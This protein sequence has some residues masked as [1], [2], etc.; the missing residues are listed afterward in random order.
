MRA[1][2]DIRAAMRWAYVYIPLRQRALASSAHAVTLLIGAQSCELVVRNARAPVRG[3]GQRFD[4]IGK[5][6]NA[7]TSQTLRLLELLHRAERTLAALLPV[8]RE[9]HA[10]RLC[11]GSADER[12]RFS[13]CGAGSD[14]I[15]D[16]HYPT[17]ERGADD[18]A[19]LAMLL[20]L[21]AVVGVR[22]FQLGIQRERD[23]GGGGER[24][25]LVRGTKEHIE[26]EPGGDDG[27]GIAAAEQRRRFPIAEESRVEEVGAVASGFEREAPEAQRFASQ[28]EVD[29][30][31]LVLLHA[32]SLRHARNHRQRLRHPLGGREGPVSLVAPAAGGFHLSAGDQEPGASAR[33]T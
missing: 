9:R 17:L 33:G 2:R 11:S 28:R 1:E 24:N 7:H 18:T 13:H 10:H 3:M 31:E 15:I 4:E 29:E 25:A 27:G 26:G 21:L 14:D 30:G 23:G 16:D 32:I 22:H 20:R 5:C 12:D 6:D 19:A 8:E